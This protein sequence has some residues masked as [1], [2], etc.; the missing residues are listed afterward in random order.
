[1]KYIIYKSTRLPGILS[2]SGGTWDQAGIRN[3]YK[4][5]YDDKEEALELA[6][7]LSSYNGVGFEVEPIND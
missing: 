5:Q 7:I 4:E 2:Y 3:R 6:S 1:M